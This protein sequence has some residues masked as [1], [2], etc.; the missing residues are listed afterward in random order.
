[1]PAYAFNAADARRIAEIVRAAEHGRIGKSDLGSDS[2]EG[3]KPGVRLLIAKHEGGEWATDATAVV[4]IYN[5]DAGD[6]AS[7]ATVVAYNQYIRFSAEP[8]CTSRWVS[9]GHNGFNWIPVDAQDDCD[10]CDSEIGGID[11]AVFPGFAKTNVQILG[12]DSLGCIKW[13]DIFT[14]ATAAS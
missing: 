10:A 14:C 13:Y 8:V 5:G 6:I 3:A 9:L 7:A 1:M 2:P 12:H 11:F 4:T